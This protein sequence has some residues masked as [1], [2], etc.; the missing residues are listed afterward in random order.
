MIFL[1]MSPMHAE[2]TIT[3]CDEITDWETDLLIQSYG[4][5]W[6]MFLVKLF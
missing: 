2:L 3:I 1:K 6:D 4:L 5:S